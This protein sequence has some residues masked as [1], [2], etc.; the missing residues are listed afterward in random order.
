MDGFGL[1][2][3]AGAVLLA[4]GALAVLRRRQVTCP[5]GSETG[6]PKSCHESNPSLSHPVS[7]R[8]TT[9]LEPSEL[10]PPNFAA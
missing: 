8:R 1:A 7:P 10:A 3:M 2:M 6:S 4:A 9:G 5:D